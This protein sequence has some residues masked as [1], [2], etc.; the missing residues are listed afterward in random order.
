M[1]IMMIANDTNFVWNLRREILE[2][3]VKQGYRVTLVAEILDFKDELEKIG[4]SIINIQNSRRG[5]NPFKD[6][7][8]LF[9]YCT[10]LSRVKPD[11]VFTNNIK[12]NAYGGIACQFHKTKY[13][14]NITGLGTPIEIP[15][16]LQ[17][18]TIKLYKLGVRK[19]STIFFQNQENID[20]FVSHKMISKN[21][22]IVLLPGSG[23]NLEAH[24][25][26]PWPDG[27]IHFLFVARVMKEKGIDY[28]LAAAHEFA[29]PNIIFDVCGQCDDPYYQEL[30]DNDSS[31]VYH[32]LQKEMKPFY[33][34]CSCLLFPSYYPEGMSNVLL[35]AAASGRPLITTDRSGCREIVDDNVTGFIV[36]IK[37]ETAVIDAVRHFLDLSC[38]DRKK[39]GFAGRE[40][41]AQ[42]FDRKKVVEEYIKEIIIIF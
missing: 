1:H 42:E 36:P 38:E 12:P 34:Q 20:F 27:S 11:I 35:E 2:E 5:K 9:K 4:V 24:P 7:H 31:I 30:L 19:A 3:F 28:F 29:S 41:V 21:S 6:I 23:V 13:I 37:D 25:I 22:K 32:G 17:K 15:G 18:L 14:P 39:M 8:L 33:S 40:K 10:I 16:K 26:L